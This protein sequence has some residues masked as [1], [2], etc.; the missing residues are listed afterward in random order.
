MK[1]GIMLR[2]MD[3]HGGGVIVYT[4]SLLPALF[5]LETNHEFILIYQNPDHL[6]TYRHFEQVRE[7]AVAT[8]TKILWDQLGV[9][10]V[11]KRQKL[12]IIFNPKYSIPLRSDCPS[13]WVCHG[14]DWYVMPWGS[15]WIDRVSH[16][17][18]V[19]MYA[20][21]AD[22]IIA[23][24][25][26]TRQHLLNFLKVDGDQVSTVHL[27]VD[28]NFRQPVS[29]EH[30]EQVRRDFELP[31]RFFLYVGQIYPAKNFKRLVQAYAQVGPKL[32]IHLLV[33]GCYASRWKRELQF[34]EKLGLDDW[35]RQV[36]WIDRETLPAYYA[37]AEALVLPSLYEAC[38]SPPIEAMAIGCPVLT[39]NRYGTKE[40]AGQAALLVDPD[41][42]DSISD[43]MHRLVTDQDLRAQ[44][45]AAGYSRSKDFSWTKCAQET[46]AF[47]EKVHSTATGS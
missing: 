14:L 44:L 28:E 41:Q 5:D 36:G 17:Y 29:P 9:R 30:K 24:S 27:G 8:P 15:P 10:R 32:G 22:G 3:Q 47:L 20:R 43:G 11:E 40:I 46:I 45:I 21:R 19:P 16:R 7:I 37:L 18:L 6:G 1:V 39:A 38:P 42:V 34:I 4:K 31:E 33:A 26:T 2:H 12:D 13:V 25:D 35:V 23:V